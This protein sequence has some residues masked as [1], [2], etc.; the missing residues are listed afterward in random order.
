MPPYV[1]AGNDLPNIEE[2]HDRW[3]SG[4]QVVPW[5]T[6]PRE[7]LHAATAIR[8]G[9]ALPPVFGDSHLHGR[10]FENDD[11]LDPGGKILPKAC[12]DCISASFKSHL[13]TAGTTCRRDCRDR[14][15][16]LAKQREEAE[17]QAGAC[18]GSASPTL[19]RRHRRDPSWLRPESNRHRRQPL[20]RWSNSIRMTGSAQRSA[21]FETNSAAHC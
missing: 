10:Q 20:R 6:Y 3:H 8:A 7:I 5:R 11:S 19:V 12:G 15:A 13:Q 1:F 14:R 17:C 4:I 2:T 21:G 16:R 18:C 9:L